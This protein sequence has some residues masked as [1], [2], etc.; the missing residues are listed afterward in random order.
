ML[1]LCILYLS[2]KSNTIINN[3]NNKNIYIYKQPITKKKNCT[4][5]YFVAEICY[6]CLILVYKI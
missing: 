3:N 5:K 2:I 6:L 4:K 1:L